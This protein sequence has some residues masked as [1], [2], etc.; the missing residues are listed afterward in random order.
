MRQEFVP[1][2]AAAQPGEPSAETE[3]Q[4]FELCPWASE[5]VA[6][7]GGWRAF[8]SVRDCETWQRQV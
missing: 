7:E 2:P 5:V 6:V 3:A 8:E 1:R 4:V